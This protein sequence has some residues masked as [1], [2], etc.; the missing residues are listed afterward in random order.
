M[1]SFLTQCWVRSLSFHGG[2]PRCLMQSSSYR[3]KRDQG[4]RSLEGAQCPGEQDYFHQSRKLLLHSWR[5]D[6]TNGNWT[7][8]RL[9]KAS[10][11]F[12]RGSLS[13]ELSRVGLTR[14]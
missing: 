3:G 11:H 1:S 14:D 6:K 7:R 8:L 5:D 4:S 9:H 2:T 13:S 10:L 12:A